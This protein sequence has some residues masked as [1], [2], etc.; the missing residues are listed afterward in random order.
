MKISVQISKI[1]N[2]KIEELVQKEIYL[3]KSDFV[4]H[5]IRLNLEKIEENN[6]QKLKEKKNIFNQLR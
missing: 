1:D 2:K 6:K 4:R 3:S 5:S